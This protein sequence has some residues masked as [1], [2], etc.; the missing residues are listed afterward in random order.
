MGETHNSFDIAQYFHT[1][2]RRLSTYVQNATE[3]S[4]FLLIL[5]AEV[6]DANTKLQ[7]LVKERLGEDAPALFV[8]AS[9]IAKQDTVD[10]KTCAFNNKTMAHIKAQLHKAISTYYPRACILVYTHTSTYAARG[11]VEALVQEAY[12]AILQAWKNHA[13]L[14]VLGGRWIRNIWKNI[15]LPLR[16]PSVKTLN[17]GMPTISGHACVVGAGPS[18]DAQVLEMLRHHRNKLV[19]IACDTALP[20][21]YKNNIVPDICVVLE[22]QYYN[23]RD[24]IPPPN[25]SVHLLC[26]ISAYPAS[27]R[28]FSKAWLFCTEF[29][30]LSFFKRI[31]TAFGTQMPALGCVGVS[32][33]HIALHSGAQGV[34]LAGLDFAFYKGR[35]HCLHAPAHTVHMV[36]HTRCNPWPSAVAHFLH[37]GLHP[38]ES[39]AQNTGAMKVS[40][41]TLTGYANELKS[42][43]KNFRTSDGGENIHEVNNPQSMLKPI[44]KHRSLEYYDSMLATAPP[45]TL[46][47]ETQC[48]PKEKLEA[49]LAQELAYAS[50]V[51]ET[52]ARCKSRATTPPYELWNTHLDF[53]CCTLFEDAYQI[54][55]SMKKGDAAYWKESMLYEKIQLNA[56]R[57]VQDI[58]ACLA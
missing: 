41:K 8:S 39:A 28:F 14:G 7:E 32:S 1:L 13:T 43:L 57:V 34:V 26:D 31:G 22:S 21:L 5:P 55:Q 29:A 27:T 10:A 30:P 42:M 58:R 4:L 51:Q 40:D 23:I 19:L 17:T 37:Q 52:M 54:R 38:L 25:R 33:A 3:R 2:S 11:A 46:Q 36:G 15:S 6:S 56:A 12:E 49:I 48:I 45:A 47:W 50:Y 44:E 20:A 35:S 53:Y 24:F 9:S 16:S 18:L